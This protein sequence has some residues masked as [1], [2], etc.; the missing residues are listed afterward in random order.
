MASPITPPFGKADALTMMRALA[1]L[2]TNGSLGSFSSVYKQLPFSA[3]S[4]P[5]MAT[6]EEVSEFCR[7]MPH[8][9][10]YESYTTTQ[11]K[12][13]FFLESADLDPLVY[14]TGGWGAGRLRMY[15]MGDL[16]KAC[17]GKYGV[18]GAVDKFQAKAS[19]EDNKR[20]RDS[21]KIAKAAHAKATLVAMPCAVK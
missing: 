15:E 12:Q 6:K 8:L 17:V 20:K 7:R 11:A 16:L 5:R 1:G 18:D 19:R 10:F 21:E 4:A 13:K 9:S 14:L 3:P 2:P